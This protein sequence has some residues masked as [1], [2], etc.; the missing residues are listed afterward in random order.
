LTITLLSE[1]AGVMNIC[2]ISETAAWGGAEIHTVE[3][4]ET[5]AGRGHRIH[6]VALGHEVFNEA[7]RRPGAAF[8][9]HHVPLAKPVKQLTW[10]ECQA[11]V[12][13]L[14]GGVGVLVRWGLAVGS[15]RLDLAAQLRFRRY[16]AIEHSTVALP[17]RG[18]GRWCRG[19]LPGLGLW[20]YQ[21][22]LLWQLRS[23]LSHL[24]VCVS[25]GARRRLIRDF[26][27]PRRKVVTVHC[28]IDTARFRPDPARRA[29]TRRQW[30]V[31]DDALVFG[32]VGRLHPDKGL[33]VAI[34]GLGQLAARFPQWDLRL[35]LV[36]DGPARESLL[37]QAQTAGV[38]DR[39]L[40]AGFSARPWEAYP[41]MDVFLMPTREEALPLALIEAMAS[42]CLPIAMGV[43]GVPEVLGQPQAGWLVP[44]ENRVRFV[45][46]MEAVVRLEMCQRAAMVRAARAHVVERF[47]AARQYATLADLIE[48]RRPSALLS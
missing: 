12:R 48:L 5:L 11:L 23:A 40:F 27:V 28:G 18:S 31:A 25:Q 6:I 15:L 1:A 3:L 34:E 33:D 16:I 10:P 26:H 46:R 19:L 21:G 2:F 13:G 7:G 41:G 42:G 24:V 47:D 22:R 45:E 43:G 38:A 30:G 8:K 20:R 9:V 29:A 14:P 37:R 36:G 32:S 39:V 35:V 44:A 4:A 17:P